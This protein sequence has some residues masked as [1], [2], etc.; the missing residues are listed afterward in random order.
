MVHVGRTAHGRP[1]LRP[2]RPAVPPYGQPPSREQV[3]P[4]LHIGARESPKPTHTSRVDKIHRVPRIPVTAAAQLPRP[5][6]AERREGRPEFVAPAQEPL[7]ERPQ[8][9]Q[10]GRGAGPDWRNVLWHQDPATGQPH[11]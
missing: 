9:R 2:R 10:L 11:V 8:G 1:L 4:A 3:L 6:A 7:C 5:A